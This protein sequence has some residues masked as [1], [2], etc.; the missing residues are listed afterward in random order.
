MAEP[1]IAGAGL[2]ERGGAAAFR[3]LALIELA[4]LVG[5]CGFT[6]SL[7]NECVLTVNSGAG[8]ICRCAIAVR[9]YSRGARPF[10]QSPPWAGRAAVSTATLS[11]CS[12][13][14]EYCAR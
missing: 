10:T 11:N 8:A 14:T 13:A 2:A 7:E 6:R 3:R 12:V 1:G 5:D 9:Y 4:V